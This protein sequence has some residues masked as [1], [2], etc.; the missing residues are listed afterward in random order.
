MFSHYCRPSTISSRET[1]PRPLAD[2]VAAA[3]VGLLT[4]V[5]SPEDVRS[6]AATADLAPQPL[7]L[8]IKQELDLERFS[9][10]CV[11]QQHQQQ[12]H[13]PPPT[14]T[15]ERPFNCNICSYAA[16]EAWKLKRHMALHKQKYPLRNVNAT[17]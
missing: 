8:L 11:Q 1:T 4:R 3:A 12:R 13:L 17:L 7:L 2:V 9:P 6:T 5:L 15:D 16:S 14:H 10:V